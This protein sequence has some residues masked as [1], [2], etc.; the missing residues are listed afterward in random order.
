MNN[1]KIIKTIICP[2]IKCRKIVKLQGVPREKIMV[3][4]P[5][6]NT[7]GYYLFPIKRDIT[8]L[9]IK[10]LLL[11]QVPYILIIMSIFISY[12]IFHGENLATLLSFLILIPIFVFFKFD[13]R[14][15]IGYALL[16]FALSVVALVFYKNEGY[17]N[18]L[19][20]YT[21]W[22]LVVGIICLS[23]EYLIKQRKSNLLK[24]SG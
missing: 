5:K 20:I 16:M 7:K 14:I 9:T 3:T 11:S 22:L 18:L 1:K 15:P 23:V 8:D 6:C 19:A 13:G 2:N 17:A 24:Q 4:C 10:S 12:F 21:Y